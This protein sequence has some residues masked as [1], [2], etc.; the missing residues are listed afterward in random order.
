MSISVAN[1]LTQKA[2]KFG[3][4]ETSAD[5]QQIFLDAVNYTLSDI[6]ERCG[7]SPDTVDA[8]GETIDLDRQQFEL[9]LAMGV[10]F[11]IVDHGEWTTQNADN[12]RARYERKLSY[13]H[14]NYLRSLDLSAKF[15]TFD[16]D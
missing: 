8:I 12:L 2:R 11:Y 5:F 1:M 6:S 14:T 7:L 16:D 15:G 13:V 4:S 9:V 10:D 3:A